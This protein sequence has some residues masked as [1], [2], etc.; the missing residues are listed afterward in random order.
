[1]KNGQAFFIQKLITH[2][3]INIFYHC[4]VKCLKKMNTYLKLAENLD[5]LYWEQYHEYTSK[6]TLSNPFT[7]I[8]FNPSID[9]F[10]SV[11]VKRI[12]KNVDVYVF[13]KDGNCV[14]SV[15]FLKGANYGYCSFLPDKASNMAF[16]VKEVFQKNFQGEKIRI[17]TS[18]QEVKAMLESLNGKC[19]IHDAI[20]ELYLDRIDKDNIYDMI[21]SSKSFLSDAHLK[22]DFFSFLP[23]TVLD[24][25]IQFH[26]DVVSDI[27]VLDMENGEEAIDKNMILKKY[28]VLRERGGDIVYLIVFNSKAEIVGLTEVWLQDKKRGANISGGLTA[29][30]TDY[31]RKRMAQ[32]LK[33]KMISFLMENFENF[34]V[35]NT[36]NSMANTPILNLNKKLGFNQVSEEF[37]IDYKVNKQKD[38]L[39][40]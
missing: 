17:T 10:K 27:I 4:Q 1:M 32:F 5:T 29:V 13:F 11:I 21:N 3:I 28:K 39:N 20:Q 9:E 6:M 38:S 31:R 8:Y 36:A 23:D 25:Y 24:K 14:G 16:K 7:H 2:E 30:R 12:L 40:K 18:Q 26:N 22:Y 15:E 33:A 19:V 35:L 37:I 34:T